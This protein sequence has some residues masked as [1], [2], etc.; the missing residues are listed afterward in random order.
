MAWKNLKQRS[1]TYAT[2]VAH[3]AVKEL[4]ELNKLI[5]WSRVEQHLSHL[6]PKSRS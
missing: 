5:D 1:L 4:D 2:I 3:E 6:H